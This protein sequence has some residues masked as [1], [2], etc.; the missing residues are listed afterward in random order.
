LATVGAHGDSRA[1]LALPQQSISNASVMPKQFEAPTRAEQPSWPEQLVRFLDD[2]IR[3]PGMNVRIGFDGI[4]G[5]FLPAVGDAMTAAGAL[6]LFWLAVRRGVPKVVLLRM[7]INLAVDAL[8]GAV[9]IVGD[10]YDFAW[11]SNRKNLQLIERSTPTAPGRKPA[12]TLGDVLVVASVACL[13]AAALALP[14]LI[15]GFLIT[16]LWQA[17]S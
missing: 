2:G 5:L 10:V 13:I 3:V 7:A 16:A 17:M 4:M 1:P 12:R 11:K 14:F 15:T 6:S 9:P 8:I